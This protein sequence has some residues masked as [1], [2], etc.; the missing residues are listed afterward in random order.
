VW[1]FMPKLAA[2]LAPEPKDFERG[3]AP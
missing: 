3:S 1:R 2:Y